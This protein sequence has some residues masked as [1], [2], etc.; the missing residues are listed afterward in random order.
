MLFCSGNLTGF[1]LYPHFLAL[2]NQPPNIDGWLY[3]FKRK[4][5]NL[6]FDII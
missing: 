5:F 6:F 4:G 2:K 3:A 1:M